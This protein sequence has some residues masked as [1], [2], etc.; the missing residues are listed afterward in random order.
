[1]GH[2]I[3]TP[4]LPLH[5][6]PKQIIKTIRT[7]HIT[8]TPPTKNNNKNYSYPPHYYCT[9]NPKNIIKTIHTPHITIAPPT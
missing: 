4:T 7:P 5:R 1:L 2:S 6:Q 8:I 3:R 9:T